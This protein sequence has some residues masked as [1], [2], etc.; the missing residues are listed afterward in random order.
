MSKELHYRRKDDKYA[1]YSTIIDDYITNW[2]DKET[3]KNI[4][5]GDIVRNSVEKVN[6]YMVQIDKEV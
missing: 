4:W 3:L 2:E 5:I 1:L 6:R